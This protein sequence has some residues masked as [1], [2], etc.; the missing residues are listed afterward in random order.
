M[1]YLLTRLPSIGCE[2]NPNLPRKITSL[3]RFAI[4]M[5]F[6]GFLG[7][8]VVTTGAGFTLGTYFYVIDPALRQ[9]IGPTAT[10]QF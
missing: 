10:R 6:I 2:V 1:F 4:V 5:E 8:G 7:Q 3:I 9:F